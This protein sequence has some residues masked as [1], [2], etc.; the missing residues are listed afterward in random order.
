M[1]SL[2]NVSAAHGTAYYKLENYYT[3]KESVG[4]SRWVGKDAEKLGLTGAVDNAIFSHLLK[5]THTRIAVAGS[6]ENRKRSGLDLTF[7]APKSVSVQA[8]VFGDNRIVSA[9]RDAVNETLGFVEKNF[10][11]YRSGGKNDRI[12]Q[13]AKGILVA[14]FEHDSSR[15]KDPQ[16]HTHNVIVNRIENKSGAI[17]ALHSDLIYKNSVLVGMVYQNS[18]AKKM[19]ELG[20]KVRPNA[21][22]TFEIEGFSKNQ[23]AIFSKRK[24]QI[25]A[26]NPESYQHTRDL[27]LKNRKAKE[28]PQ[29]RESLI[30]KWENEAAENKIVRIQSTKE[31]AKYTNQNKNQAAFKN[32]PVFEFMEQAIGAVTVKSSV[33]KKEDVLREAI[34]ISLGKFSIFELEK[35][36]EN[37]KSDKVLSTLK[38]DVFTTKEAVKREL[39]TRAAVE[40][41]IGTFEPIASSETAKLRTAKIQKIEPNSAQIVLE[42]THDALLEKGIK[43]KDAEIIL[44]R[45][46]GAIQTENRI[47]ISQITAVRK[48]LI[49]SMGSKGALKNEQETHKWVSEIMKPIAKEFMAPTQGQIE[50]IEKTLVSKDKYVVWQGV[51]GGGKTH[52]VRQIVEAALLE[53]FNVQGFAPSA[54]AATEL[55]KEIGIKTETLQSHILKRDKNSAEKSIWI[56]DEAGMIS[57][58]DFHSLQ[59][60]ANLQNA[61]VLLIGDYRQLPPVDAG[62]PF[63]DIQRKT[64]TTVIHLTESLRQK[65]QLLQ[66][67]VA[68]MNRGNVAGGVQILKEKTL[69]FSTEKGRRNFVAREFLSKSAEEQNDSLLLTRTNHLRE[70]LTAEIR[71]GLKEKGLLKNEIQL[72]VLRKIDVAESRLK[73]AH[74]YSEGDILI[75]NRNYLKWGLEKDQQYEIKS[76][77]IRKNNIMVEKNNIKIEIPVQRHNQFSLFSKGTLSVAEGDKMM[78]NRNLKSREQTNNGVFMVEKIDKDGILIRAE[79]GQRKLLNAS[80]PQH[81]EHAWALTIYKSQGKTTSTVLQIVDH[82]TTKRD[83]LV[84]VTRAAHDVLLVAPSREMVFKRAEIDSQKVIAADE[85]EDVAARRMKANWSRV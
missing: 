48:S 33:F 59:L 50:A 5:G 17:R 7:S 43:Q 44:E 36:F 4:Y 24:E 46:F 2:A 54:T 6:L 73:Q 3:E 9:H 10:A 85:I 27:V 68:L 30:E 40:N 45:L 56:V 42:K 76:T 53:G 58:K 38:K 49:Q 83:L 21:H 23:L 79:N 32:A 80:E 16:L 37:V 51:P 75:P 11:V 20:Y 22:G 55:A 65:D 47:S 26:M 14:Q 70:D 13:K 34:Q 35:A 63:L 29:K 78:W 66:E 60:K 15:L 28:G 72:P 69:E 8:L 52:A 25:E 82:E 71:R 64:Q 81:M 67:S 57:A 39:Q 31:N 12:V 41:G 62:N 1:L 84:G 61:R 74:F 18:L 77:N 19:N